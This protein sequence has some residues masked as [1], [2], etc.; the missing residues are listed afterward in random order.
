MF[1]AFAILNDAGN[2]GFQWGTDRTHI[3]KKARTQRA[4]VKKLRGAIDDI[5]GNEETAEIVCVE[6]HDALEA[7]HDAPSAGE[8]IDN[9]WLIV[10]DYLS[11]VNFAKQL[12]VRPHHQYFLSEDMRNLEEWDQAETDFDPAW[13]TYL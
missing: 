4:A 1:Y 9:T 10:A 3:V 2:V 8:M 12:G 13:I 5:G 11:F 6:A 7:L